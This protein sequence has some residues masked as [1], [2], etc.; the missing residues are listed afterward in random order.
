MPGALR[1][2]ENAG[3]GICRE[4]GSC[5]DVLAGHNMTSV[6]HYSNAGIGRLRAA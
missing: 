2:S 6:E 3:C 4:D 5:A 1:T